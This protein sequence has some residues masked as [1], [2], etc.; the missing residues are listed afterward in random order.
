MPTATFPEILMGFSSDGCHE[1]SDSTG[2]VEF[3]MNAT[4]FNPLK[5]DW[6][7]FTKSV[8]NRIFRCVLWLIA[9]T[10]FSPVHRP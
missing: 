5:R 8:N 7:K 10:T 2:K 6:P 3:I 4:R 1:R 9:S